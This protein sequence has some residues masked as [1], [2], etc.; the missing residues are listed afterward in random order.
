MERLARTL[1]RIFA[2]ALDLPEAYFDPFENQH[3]SALRCLNYPHSDK[4]FAPGQMRIAPHTDYGTLTILRCASCEGGR[5][6]TREQRVRIAAPDASSLLLLIHSI[7]RSQ[8]CD[9]ELTMPPAGC[10]C[11]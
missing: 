11:R 7:P 4:P 6:A 9:A 5:R 2:L 1:L 8:L 10:R 3:W